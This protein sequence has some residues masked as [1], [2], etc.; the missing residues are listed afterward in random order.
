MY[1]LPPDLIVHENYRVGLHALCQIRNIHHSCLQES[2]DPEAMTK[3]LMGYG[4]QGGL[5][6]ASFILPSTGYV[7]I[8]KSIPKGIRMN[9]LVARCSRKKRGKERERLGTEYLHNV[10]SLA[11]KMC[12]CDQVHFPPREEYDSD[13]EEEEGKPLT[14]EELRARALKGVGQST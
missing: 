7:N 9:S 8:S 10:S 11:M 12:T 2:E 14:Q 4:P 1:R 5:A 3:F 13:E 6:A